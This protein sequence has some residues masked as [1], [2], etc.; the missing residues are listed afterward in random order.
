MKRFINLG[1]FLILSFYI[2][3]LSAQRTVTGKIQEA[4]GQPII[5]ATV[6]AQ[7]TSLGTTTNESG[8]FTLQIPA[9]VNSL[10]VN[11]IG[12]APKEVFI[13]DELTIDIVL[14]EGKILET[15]FIIGSRSTAAR[16]KTETTAP[17][18]VLNI[19]ELVATGQT[20]PT[21]MLHYIVPSFNSGRQTVADG[22]DHIDPSTLRGLGPDQVLTLLNGK[23]RHN[24]AL[25]NINGTIGRGS[26]GTDMNAIPSAAIERLE[27]LRDGASSQYGSDAIAGVINVVMKNTPGTTITGHVSS[28]NTQ[29]EYLFGK[30]DKRKMTDGETV[31]LSAYHGMAIAKGK[32]SVA[33]EFRDR[34]ASNRSGDFLG[35]VYHGTKATDDSL[36]NA[37]GGFD[38]TFNMQVG[39]AASRNIL[40]F[41]NYNLPIGTN[42]ELYINMGGASRKGSGKG[43][44]RY[45]KQTTQVIPELY[46]M[47]FLPEIHSTIG[48]Y[49][50]LIGLK[51]IVSNG[52]RWDLSNVFGT[53]RFRYDVKNSNNASQFALKTAAPTEFYAGTQQFSQNTTN[54]ELSKALKSNAVRSL[55]LALGLELRIDNFKIEA[56]E[57]ASWKNYD[58]N[59]KP[60]R[61]GGSQVFPGFQPGNEV[62]QG[63]TVAGAFIDLESDI[64]DK[65]LVNAAARFENY[66]DFGTNAAA[67]LAARYKF[68]DAF[69]IR[70]A[71]SNGF[72][73][74]SVHQRYF[75]NTSTQFVVANGVTTPNNVGTYRND[76]EIAKALGIPSLEAEKSTNISLGVTSKFAKVVSLTIDAYQINIKDRIVITGNMSR[77]NALINSLLIAGGAAADVTQVA[78]FTNAIN[79]STRGIDA[80]LG[81]S[82]KMGNG[83][84]DLTLAANFTKN[85]IDGPIK[86]TDKLPADDFGK[87]FFSRLEESRVVVGQPKSKIAASLGYR[88]VNFSTQ[89]RAT[90]FG[91]VAVWDNTNMVLDESFSSKTIVDLNLSYTFKIATLSLGSN[92]LFDV[93][94][95]KI[96]NLGN[97]SDGRF[98]YSRNVTQ[99]G[100]GGRTLYTA[101]KIDIK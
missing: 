75:S 80:V 44:Y 84:L 79:T 71:L 41:V 45:P 46:P 98:I 22:T 81:A 40:G 33:L 36:I 88:I 51:G 23:R 6:M 90:R 18:D 66:S 73:A 92:N 12:Y 32:F 62:N 2:T 99:F 26:V 61:V 3:T 7:G 50:A 38:R 97:T 100:F 57:E 34:K 59:A 28:Y 77:S 21:Q 39:N 87:T 17:V 52:W 60:L 76:S 16:T 4:N 70:G 95:D 94:P 19:T 91:E 43:F 27:V 14:E 68:A 11:Y 69:V 78:F 85:E 101:L 83:F 24:Q 8:V 93:Y 13:G 56:G 37:R 29:Y 74:P 86:T 31:Q 42:K 67:K 25:I 65:F 89:L 64:T 9:N 53:N 35:T 20:D 96:K 82:P 72:R 10:T 48:D 1:L 55:N 54:F 58:L 5:G 47:G 49:S 63:R 15:V 30:N